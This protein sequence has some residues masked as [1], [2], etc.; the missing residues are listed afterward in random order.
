[1]Q[2]MTQE[3]ISFP[4]RLAELYQIHGWLP[5]FVVFVFFV[6]NPLCQIKAS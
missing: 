2:A 1:M 3:Q 4:M 6:V 5:F